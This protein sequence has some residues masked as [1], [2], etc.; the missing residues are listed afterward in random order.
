MG[1]SI[2]DELF[3]RQ[4]VNVSLEDAI[5]AVG[6]LCQVGDIAQEFDVFGAQLLHQRENIVHSILQKSPHSTSLLLTLMDNSF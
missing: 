1:N 3:D 4:G 2:H 5:A 6:E